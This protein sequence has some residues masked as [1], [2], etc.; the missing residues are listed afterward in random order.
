MKTMWHHH[1]HVR[2]GDELTLGERAADAVRN[3]MGS[4][5]FIW[6]QTAFIVAWVTLNVI[7]IVARWDPFPFILLNL[8]FSVQAAY[9][10]PIILLSQ[11]RGDQ[12]SSELALSTHDNGVK[13]LDLN[14][15]QL[16][17]LEQLREMRETLK[18]LAP[19]PTPAAETPNAGTGGYC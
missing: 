4:W 9:A 17:I 16:E 1:P 13:L 6:L 11:R 14:Q 3:G 10:S 19:D 18:E 15:R 7:G 5:A 12:K 8:A 2:S